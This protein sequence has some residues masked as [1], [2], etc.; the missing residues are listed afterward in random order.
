M[1]PG[2]KRFPFMP[3]SR[4]E[5]VEA[6]ASLT[7]KVLADISSAARRMDRMET[8]AVPNAEVVLTSPQ[9]VASYCENIAADLVRA[10]ARIREAA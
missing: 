7:Q 6:A 10:A 1:I 5:K 9:E 2:E 4:R 3:T 8:D